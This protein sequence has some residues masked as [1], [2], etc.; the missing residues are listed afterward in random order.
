M[1]YPGFTKY[2][3]AHSVSATTLG[4]SAQRR[5]LVAQAL[6]THQYPKNRKEEG[7]IAWRP[8]SSMCLKSG[9]DKTNWIILLSYVL[10]SL[11]CGTRSP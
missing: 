5:R 7:A 11:L 3:D 1:A 4:E 8:F 2:S 10:N 6:G 9:P